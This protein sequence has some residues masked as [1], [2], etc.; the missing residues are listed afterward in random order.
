MAAGLNG[1][2]AQLGEHLPCK[3]GVKSSNLSI[4]ISQQKLTICTLKTEYWMKDF[5]QKL[6]LKDIENPEQ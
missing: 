2:V 1:G 5:N 3:Q 6:R 4:S